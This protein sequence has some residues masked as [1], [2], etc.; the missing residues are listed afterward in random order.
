MKIV[1]I[2]VGNTLFKDE[3]VGVFASHYIAENFSFSPEIEIIDGG[4]LGFKL[5]TYLQDYDKVLILDTVSIEDKVGSIY[6]IPAEELVGLGNYRKTAHEVEVVQMIEI[7]SMM[8][9]ISDVSVVGI[10][11]KDIE[12]TEIGLTESMKEKFLEFVNVAI[13]EIKSCN[14]EVTESKKMTLED[15]ELFYGKKSNLEVN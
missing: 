7:C 14:I 2:G 13:E 11:P 8:D 5:M 12:A 1:V 6:K 15:I 10:I 9:K 3:G 4:T